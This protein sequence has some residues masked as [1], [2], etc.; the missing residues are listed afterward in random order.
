MSLSRAFT[1][2]RGRAT[3]DSS[4]SSFLPQRSNTTTKGGPNIRSKISGPVELVHTTNMLS[5]NAP[6]LPRSPLRDLPLPLPSI[7][8]GSSGSKSEDD[9][10]TLN[11]LESTPPTSPDVAS[12]DQSSSPDMKNHL[13]TYFT[14]PVKP[15]A[16]ANSQSDAPTIPKRSPS[17]TK[18]A[19]YDAISR[20]QSVSRMSKGSENTLSSKASM[21]FSRSSSTSTNLS[22]MSTHSRKLSAPPRPAAPLSPISMQSTPV[23]EAHPFGQELAQVTELVEEIVTGETTQTNDEDAKYLASKGLVRFGVADYMSIVDELALNFFPDTSHIRAAG[24]LWI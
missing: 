15:L 9:S 21:T 19:S 11:T 2:R 10:D 22:H 8:T 23:K 5:Y 24:P 20:S 13:S 1:T 7:T 4:E 3:G 12:G 16:T 18:K 14:V 17:H 6:D